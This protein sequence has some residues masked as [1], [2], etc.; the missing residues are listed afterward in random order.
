MRYMPL[1][2]GLWI[3]FTLLLMAVFGK[4]Q[5]AMLLSGVYSAVAWMVL[6]LFVLQMN[7]KQ[8]FLKPHLA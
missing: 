6:G 1:T 7:A 5:S 4:S 8:T 2:V 3:P